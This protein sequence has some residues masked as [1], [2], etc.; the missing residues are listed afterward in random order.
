[1]KAQIGKYLKNGRKKINVHIDEYDSWN[2][3]HTMSY[4]ILP[5]LLQLRDTSKSIPAE[6]ADTKSEDYTGQL[7]FD[8]YKENENEVFEKCIANWN[9]TLDK[10]I[11]SFQ[12]LVHDDY[13]SLYHHGVPKFSWKETGETMYDPITKQNEKLFEM[14]DDNPNEHWYDIE[15]HRLHEER[16]REGLELF[17]KYFTNLWD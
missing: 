3:A 17:G 5:I 10:M 13:D 1:M 14:I 4:I 9:E 16:I 8:F 7:T 12:Q 6:F 15:G 11:W 2:A